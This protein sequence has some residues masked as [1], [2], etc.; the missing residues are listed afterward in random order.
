MTTIP[1]LVYA[2]LE[3]AQ[4]VK[5]NVKNTFVTFPKISLICSSVIMTK[6]ND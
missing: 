3:G 5:A 4:K 1:T 6:L 2:R